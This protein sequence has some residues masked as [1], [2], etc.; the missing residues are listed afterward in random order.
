MSDVEK[1]IGSS[2]KNVDYLRDDSS[3]LVPQHEVK[4]NLKARHISMIA[5]GGTIGTGLFISSKNALSAGPVL[6]LI[7]YIF[8]TTLAWSVTQSLGE[9]ATYIPCSGSFTQFCTRFC[10]PALGVANGWNYW[11]SW[12]ITF[13]LELSVVGQ[14]IQ[15][16]T[17]AVPLAAWISIFFVLITVFNMFPVK[18]YGEFEFWIASLKIIAVVGWLIYALCMVCGAGQ[19]GPVGFRYWRNPGPWGSGQ[20]LVD[21]LDTDRFLAWLSSLISALFTFQGVELVGI[22]CGESHNPR[23]AVPS[24]IRKVIWRIIIFYILSMFFMGLL[25]P[26]NDPKLQSDEYFAASS[27]FIVAMHNSGTDILPSIFNAVILVAII[28]AG[29]SNVYCGSRIL[30]GLAHVGAAPKWFKLATPSGIP[31]VAVLFTAAFGALGY[32]VLDNSGN[33]VFDWLLN[34]TAVAGLIAWVNISFS[35]MRFMWILKKRNMSRD[36]LPYKAWGMPYVAYYAFILGFL[37]VF[38]Q[39]YESFFS[40]TASKFFTAYIS[41]IL[42]FAVWLVAHFYFNGFTKHAFT[43]RAWLIPLDECDIDTGVREIEEMV[44]DDAPPQNLWEKFWDILS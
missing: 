5:L 43:L 40:I 21:N 28:S 30:Y 4:R 35:H 42:F 9:M 16:W 3:E 20:G 13:A 38:V 32:L 26:Y 39:G 41:V 17:D 14:I 15:F 11:F 19:T 12:A 33:E 27:P 7:S 1:T 24:A 22:S 36:M 25:I 18:Y 6:A 44:W 29:N 23:K 2:E 8:I 34:I 37:L 31:Y 10:S